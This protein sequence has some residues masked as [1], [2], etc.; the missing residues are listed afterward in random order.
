MI[1]QREISRRA[2]QAEK[3]D[4]VIE[5][6]Y[7]IT[8]LL[9]GIPDSSLE[10]LLAF[11]GGT[12][13]KKVYFEDYRFSEDIDFTVLG[14]ADAAVLLGSL[15]EVTE[16]LA[17]DVGLIF[18]V[19]EARAESRPGSL[20]AY[21]DFVGP[22]QGA[23]GSRDIKFDFTFNEMIVFPL[24]TRRLIS[25]YSDSENL[26][27]D[28]RVYSLEE[29]LVEKMCALIGRTE[30]R[31]LY[32]AHFLLGLGDLDYESVLDG[33]SVKAEKKGIDPTRLLDVLREREPTIA[34]LWRNRLALQV[35]D[36]PHLERV[37]RETRRAIRK[38]GLK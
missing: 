17:S 34:R 18:R 23:L 19:D 22:L 29:I 15:A 35:D 9:L 28:I 21:V 8:W 3:Q 16:R 24:I 32:D 2:F 20:T 31:D 33:F 36:L 1:T 30:P 38:M 10:G 5:K 25:R 14:D 13:L 27:K 7:V 37:L 12:A 4:R 6:D 11:K 26:R